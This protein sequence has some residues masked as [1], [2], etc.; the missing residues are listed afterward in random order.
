MR[1]HFYNCIACANYPASAISN[2]FLT[3]T[4]Y[5]IGTI[6]FS[7]KG[8]K[9]IKKFMKKEIPSLQRFLNFVMK[10]ILKQRLVTT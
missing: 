6:V 1:N 2:L 5:C 10:M 7:K 8:L 3:K 4:D 9:E